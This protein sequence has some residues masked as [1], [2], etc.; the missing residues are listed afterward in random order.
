MLRRVR[1]TI[2]DVE[3]QLELNNLSGY[4]FPACNACA[5]YYLW[6]ALLYNKRHDFRKKIVI[7]HKMCV[8]ISPTTFVWKISHFK[9]KWARFN[10]KNL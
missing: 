9:K 5:P 7:E 1:A 3:K 10:K 4:S 6:P 8:L 2:V